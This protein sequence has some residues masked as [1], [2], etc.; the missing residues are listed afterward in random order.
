[1]CLKVKPADWWKA[2]AYRLH[3]G[4]VSTANQ[5]LTAAALSAGVERVFSSLGLVHSTLRNCLGNE[6]ARKLVFSSS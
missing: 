4:T 2:Q 5:L 1:M 3:Q 6:M